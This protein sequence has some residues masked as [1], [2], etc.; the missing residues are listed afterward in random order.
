MSASAESSKGSIISTPIKA[1]GMLSIFLKR[2]DNDMSVYTH[3]WAKPD[4]DRTKPTLVYGFGSLATWYLKRLLAEGLE[5]NAIFDVNPKYHDTTIAGIPVLPPDKIAEYDREFNVFIAITGYKYTL[6]KLFRDYGFTRIYNEYEPELITIEHHIANKAKYS[7]F[8]DANAQRVEQARKL[9]TEPKSIEIFDAAL[10]AWGN[11]NWERLE[12]YYQHAVVMPRD[13]FEASE[14]DVLAECGAY[15]GGGVYM[16]IGETKNQY[17]YIYAFEPGELEYLIASRSF[18]HN[19]VLNLE[20]HRM[21]VC[22]IDGTIRFSEDNS[23]QGACIIEDGGTEVPSTTLDTF[24]SRTDRA[25]PTLIRMDIE[26]A[27]ISALRGAKG[28]I[29]DFKPNLAISSYH[30]LEDYWE[31]PLTIAELGCGNYDLFFRHYRSWFDTMCFARPKR[32]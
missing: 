22:D 29:R 20:L 26:G 5:V 19:N 23:M 12:K 25:K 8:I 16:F 32:R 4:F 28:L 31:V 13:I 18:E 7:A 9:F 1:Y 17:D 2:G 30:R 3:F 14:H 10:D 27:E 11:G 15:E 24:F 21:A 6:T